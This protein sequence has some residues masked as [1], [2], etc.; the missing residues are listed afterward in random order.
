MEEAVA[1]ADCPPTPEIL[2]L[3]STPPS[4][5]RGVCSSSSSEEADE[6]TNGRR[7]PSPKCAIC[8]GKCR[9]RAYTN[10]CKHEFCFQCLLEWS[11][12]KPECPLCKQR[13]CSIVHHKTDGFVEELKLPDPH[14]GIWIPNLVQELSRTLHGAQQ[15]HLPYGTVAERLQRLLLYR[16]PDVDRFIREFG[17]EFIPPR[18]DVLEWRRFVYVHGLYSCPTAD[19]NG[20]F[21]ECSAAFYRENPS[22]VRRIFPWMNRELY[23]LGVVS[24][25]T[26]SEGLTDMLQSCDIDS[27]QFIIRLARY[28]PLEFGEHFQHELLNFARSPYDMIGYDRCVQ[29]NPRFFSRPAR[30]QVV[31]SSESDNEDIVY[32]APTAPSTS[33]ASAPSSVAVVVDPIIT[34]GDAGTDS[35]VGAGVAV[36]TTSDTSNTTTTTTS[37][38]AADNTVTAGRADDAG[39][40]RVRTEIRVELRSM[41]GTN[42]STCPTLT[43]T[44][45]RYEN[46]PPVPII[47]N[48]ENIL[49]SSSDSDDCQFVMA[50]KPP[51]LR[52]PDHVVDL[53]SGSDSDV[54]F[55]NQATTSTTQSK[56]SQLQGKPN[57]LKKETSGSH[58]YNNGASTSSGYCGGGGGSGGSVASGGASNLHRT[59]YYARPRLNRY[60]CGVG[61]KRIYEESN[62]DDSDAMFS[63][64]S[65]RRRA[66]SSTISETSL[67]DLSAHEGAGVGGV[68]SRA[69]SHHGRGRNEK[70]IDVKKPRQP[71]ATKRASRTRRRSSSSSSNCSCSSSSISSSSS[72]SSISTHVESKKTRSRRGTKRAN[73][74]SSASSRSS[75]AAI[76][77]NNTAG[78]VVAVEVRNLRNTR[79][80]QQASV[81]D[82]AEAKSRKR[83]ATRR[84]KKRKSVRKEKDIKQQSC[85]KEDE[86][87]GPSKANKSKRRKTK[88]KSQSSSKAA[89][90]SHNPDTQASKAS[91]G[92]R[93]AS[94][95]TSKSKKRTKLS[96]DHEAGSSRETPKDEAHYVI[97]SPPCN[98]PTMHVPV[99][100]GDGTGGEVRKLR[101]VIIKRCHYNKQADA[102]VRSNIREIDLTGGAEEPVREAPV[103][104]PPV[105]R[106]VAQEE[107]PS[108]SRAVSQTE[109]QENDGD[110]TGAEIADSN[111]PAVDVN[112]VDLVAPCVAPEET[113]TTSVV[114]ASELELPTGTVPGAGWCESGTSAECTVATE[115]PCN[116]LPSEQQSEQ[117]EENCV[118]HQLPPQSNDIDQQPLHHRPLIEESDTLVDAD[119]SNTGASESLFDTALNWVQAAAP[120][121]IAE[122]PGLSSTAAS[123]FSSISFPPSTTSVSP[124]LSMSS[125]SLALPTPASPLQLI[126]SI[127]P[128]DCDSPLPS[129]VLGID[130][131]EGTI[132]EIMATGVIQ[133]SSEVSATSTE[134]SATS[135]E[136]SATSTEISVTSTEVSA[137]STE[138]SV[139][140]ETATSA[141]EPDA[142]SPPCQA[143]PDVGSDGCTGT[144]VGL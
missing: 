54:V 89:K 141:P 134:L 101:S 46:E 18:S 98:S 119:D 115:E 2:P 116:I 78:V 138:V 135:T 86:P 28:I 99:D 27:R 36:A 97:A 92:R 10:S 70:K 109:R 125:Q 4:R 82:A 61:V 122:E 120:A 13:F 93:G 112:V 47:I 73:S 45:E 57:L 118:Q 96:A 106:C 124:S 69:T 85:P 66:S 5:T 40:R 130:A 111:V 137:T 22:Q 33:S 103:T 38:T 62:S 60:S 113:A 108:T 143:A 44:S 30:N 129:S 83:P 50:Q 6:T 37:S 9:Q 84:Q 32:M 133:T 16:S 39:R 55:V 114:L 51:H 65:S 53:G 24:P 117:L 58:D 42:S 140:S 128:M 3:A 63:V 127:G 144:R 95:R 74:K 91:P 67:S 132:D 68:Q 43:V 15:I 94:R 126:E 76:E 48:G 142:A 71:K 31:I 12:V 34:V 136:V 29:Y 23:A 64:S 80:R 123:P 20:R 11:K 19:I 75:S 8:L 77:P 105:E 52:T 49:L 104:T 90:S 81:V 107:E 102:P 14:N 26:R 110:R 79:S 72:S 35:N 21:R 59:K 139:E 7:S 87:A 25:N 41:Q 1:I 56:R 121:L 100:G 131:I 17:N 88:K